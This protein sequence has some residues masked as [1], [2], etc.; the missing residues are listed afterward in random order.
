MNFKKINDF[1]SS[2]RY[3]PWGIL[4]GVS[5]SYPTREVAQLLGEIGAYGCLYGG[6]MWIWGPG[7]NWDA[8]STEERCRFMDLDGNDWWMKARQESCDL[9]FVEQD[10]DG[11]LTHILKPGWV[12]DGAWV[13][14]RCN[15]GGLEWRWN[16]T[17][18]LFRGKYM[19]LYW[20]ETRSGWGG[21][22]NLGA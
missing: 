5:V 21:D 11:S 10:Q 8:I 17:L 6:E 16:I 12:W 20:G 22:V 7:L 13:D 2:L 3:R 15:L 9:N 14:L 4:V 1:R 18:L 19:D